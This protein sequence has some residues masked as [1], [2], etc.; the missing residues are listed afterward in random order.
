MQRRKVAVVNDRPVAV[1]VWAVLG[2]MLAA[3]TA[4]AQPAPPASQPAAPAGNVILNEQSYI[5]QFWTFGLERLAARPLKEDAEKFF[6]KADGGAAALTR[7]ERNSKKL[8]AKQNIDWEKVDW[9]D[10]AVYHWSRT[11]CGVD[12]R[13]AMMLP[14]IWPQADWTKPDFDDSTWPVTRFGRLSHGRLGTAAYNMNSLMYRGVYYR[15]CFDVPDPAKAGDLTVSIRYRGGARILVNGTELA[16]GH[17]GT[18]DLN[19]QTRAEDYP[20][21]AYVANDD[22]IR[23]DVPDQKRDCSQGIADLRCDWEEAGVASRRGQ[24]IF[25]GNAMA[26]QLNE[27]GW[28]RIQGLRDRSL[29]AVKVSAS[30]LRKGVNVLAIETRP[31]FLHA[32]I[33]P[34]PRERRWGVH[35]GYTNL[36]WD[37]C[38]LVRVELRGQS[39]GVPSMVARPAG[40]QVY[41][42]DMHRRLWGPDF[43]PVH[44]AQEVLRFVGAQNGTYSGQIGISTDRELTGLKA[45]ASELVMTSGGT[46]LKPVP[47]IPA[48]A[49]QVMPM[50]GQPVW[51]LNYL[52]E[53]RSIQVGYNPATPRM[54]A[55]TGELALQR[56]Q[57]LNSLPRQQ[58]RLDEKVLAKAYDDFRFFDHISATWPETVPA[59]TCQPLWVYLKL[60]ADAPE[61]V[62]KGSVT[63]QADGLPPVTIPVEAQVIGWRVP[64]PKEFQTFV[65]SEQSAYGVANQYK[66]QPWSDEHF[67][68]MDSSF[69]QLARIGVSWAYVSVLTKSELGNRDD[70]MIKWTRK[71]DGTLAFDYSIMDRYLALARKHFGTPKVVCFLVMHGTFAKSISVPIT[72]E[73]TGKTELVEVGPA[74]DATRR[75]LWRAF[76][77]SLYEHMKSLGLE[78]SMYYGQAFDD[79][80]DKSLVTILAEVTPGV[81]WTGAAH[82]RGPDATFRISSRAYGV[83]LGDTSLMGWKTPFVHMLMPRMAGSVICVEGTGTPFTYRVMVDRGLYSGFNGVGRMGAYWFGGTWFSGFSGGQWNMVGR[84]CVQTLW[85]GKD[86]P[87]ASARH[88]AMLEGVQEAEARI[89]MEQALDRNV[90]PEALAKEVQGVLDRHCHETFYIPGGAADP[91]MMDYTGDWQARSRRLFAAAAKVARQI[92]LDVDRV[93]FGQ[94][95]G[96][97]AVPAGMRSK[98]TLQLRNWSD[99]PRAWKASASDPWIAPEKAEGAVADRQN[100]TL[101]LDGKGLAEGTELSGTA[102]IT[103]A[104]SGVAYPVAISAQVVK[105]LELKLRQEIEFVSGG[106]SGSEG[107]KLIHATL[108]PVFN[109]PVGGS[110]SREF[111]LANRSAEKLAWKLQANAAW[112]KIEPAAGQIEPESS[113]RVKLTAAPPDKQAAVHEPAITLS[114]G[115]GPA[116][117]AGTVKVYVIPPYVRPAVP[118]GAAVYLNDLNQAKMVKSHMYAGFTRGVRRQRP[119]SIPEDPRPMYQLHGDPP[120]TA[121]SPFTL[122]KKTFARGLWVAPTHQTTYNVEGAGFA[123]FAAEVGFNDESVK[124]GYAN[125]G[126]VVSFEVWVDGA[127]RAQS[128]LMKFGDEP[129][130]LA[131]EGLATAKEVKLVTR[132]DSCG[133]N[134]TFLCVWANPQFYQER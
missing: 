12:E 82:G 46:G 35:G 126:A 99:K 64:S 115:A 50:Q 53:D 100:L 74:Q 39:G 127:L 71:K 19:D 72:D 7:L 34:T 111:I 26:Q 90:L 89:F 58:G 5:R 73:A 129:R 55:S 3:A 107:P 125:L 132:L 116:A 24:E 60:P 28:R 65:Q 92:G 9:R 120:K 123:A 57:V 51:T 49:V 112:L 97:V 122:A 66:V 86:G 81:Y 15:A 98:I 79:V 68:L 40:V 91:Y 45:S 14:T 42:A 16:R 48:S 121:T 41:V 75:P 37:H 63:V 8:L 105:G 54:N 33:I 47:T 130:L 59:D 31:S 61:G 114:A 106:G 17:L 70:V 62:Y 133:D 87:E 88:E 44:A 67:R 30:L 23:A 101:V 94:T 85:P 4:Q 25:R 1:T 117:D 131:V 83:D 11:Q 77:T 32:W 128:G 36:S 134:A 52:G 109:A 119:W 27:K 22:E 29:V 102:T 96:K 76:A 20:F 113:V 2:F 18:G 104:A 110:D 21:E 43:K 78:R 38:G 118:A 56:Y 108:Q 69:R 95:L 13:G 103:D 10:Q 84:S 80:P 6:P 124:N 93:A